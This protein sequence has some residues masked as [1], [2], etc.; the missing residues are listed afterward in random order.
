MDHIGFTFLRQSPFSLFS[1][2]SNTRNGAGAIAKG[3]PFHA[4]LAENRQMNVGQRGRLRQLDV[5]AAGQFAAASSDEDGRERVPIVL[6]AVR[7]VRAIQEDRVV[8]QRSLTVANR[9]QLAQELRK[10]FHVPGL[11]L[12]ELLDSPKIVGM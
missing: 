5:P 9:G 3:F 7:H 11:N 1:L 4:G 8:E 10:A 6:V 2:P 12:S